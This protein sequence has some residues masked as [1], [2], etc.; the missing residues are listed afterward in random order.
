LTYIA[1][2]IGWH[3]MRIAIFTA[4]G[5]EMPLETSKLK[6]ETANG[7]FWLT[8]KQSF[9]Q[10]TAGAEILVNAEARDRIV[11]GLKGEAK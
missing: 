6:I 11:M 10:V 9:I 1:K 7:D 5:D 3:L 8:E 4:G 2:S